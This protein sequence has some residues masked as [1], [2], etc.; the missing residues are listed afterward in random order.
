MPTGASAKVGGY[1]FTLLSEIPDI[2]NPT[3]VC[4]PPDAW[5]IFAS[6]IGEVGSGMEE[7]PF[8]FGDCGYLYPPPDPDVGVE[9]VG[10]PI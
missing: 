7:T 3:E 8:F 9:L 2:P 5:N 10:D 6:K 4:M 1:I